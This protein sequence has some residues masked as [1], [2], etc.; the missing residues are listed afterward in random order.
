MIGLSTAWISPTV[1]DDTSWFAAVESIGAKQIE[2]EYRIPAHF[3]RSLK[4]GL[5]SRSITIGSVH[6]F[7]PF[8]DEFAHLK[9]SGDLLLLSSPDREERKQ[10]VQYTIA[11]IQTAHDLE[12]SAVVLH[13]GRVEME[14]YFQDF[15][16]FYD[17]KEVGSPAMESFRDRV[18]A[19]RESRRQPFLDAVCFS[20]DELAKEAERRAVCLGLE[21]RYY[22]HEIPSC[23]EL[24]IILSRFTGAPLFHWHDV[25]HGFVQEQLGIQ[26]HLEWLERYGDRLLGVHIHDANGYHDH[27]APGTGEVD[28]AWLKP[29]VNAAQIKVLELHPKVSVEAAREGFEFLT[30]HGLD[31]DE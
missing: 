2:L 7:F 10:A 21:N 14:S 5:R 31:S 18:Q 25:G 1:Q 20:L 17:A 27:Q 19:E 15:C 24:G 4:P 30:E 3:F 8:P 9:P 12:S 13:L 22:V 26:A 29:Y 28:F 16:R 11:T 23:D 6:N